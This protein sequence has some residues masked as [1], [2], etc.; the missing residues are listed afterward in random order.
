MQ[1]KEPSKGL[2]KEK[3]SSVCKELYK[4]GMVTSLESDYAFP[5]TFSA[6]H[7][8]FQS[9]LTTCLSCD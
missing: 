3:R 5:R 1:D 9:Y 7:S 2:S 4:C 6:Y 8:L